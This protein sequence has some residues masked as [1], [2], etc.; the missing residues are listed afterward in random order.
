MEL[1]NTEITS[2]LQYYEESLIFGANTAT[3]YHLARF[4]DEEMSYYEFDYKINKIG[5][6]EQK[7]YYLLE[8]GQVWSS[9]VDINAINIAEFDLPD[10]ERAD[11]FALA[12]FHDDLTDAVVTT[13]RHL[14]LLEN[15]ISDDF[16]VNEI[17][18]ECRSNPVIADINGDG[19]N[20]IV[21][22]TANKIYAF[23]ENLILLANFPVDIPNQFQGNYFGESLFAMNLDDNSKSQEIVA[24]IENTGIITFDHKGDILSH[25][26]TITPMAR[27]SGLYNLEDETYFLSIGNGQMGSVMVSENSLTEQS[28]GKQGIDN[29]SYYYSY[30]PVADVPEN[31]ALLNKKKTFCWPNPVEENESYIRYFVTEDCDVTVNIFNMAGQH[32]KKFNQSD[33][34]TNRFN[35]ITW[36]V[37]DVQSGVYF[38]IVKA[39][40]GGT[41]ETKTVKIMVIK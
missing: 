25:M 22:A 32:I 19:N 28:W 26:A 27:F 15:I 9:T 4:Q 29:N 24:F 38:A 14:F 8:D 34:Q 1:V 40:T 3:G 18:L 20:D 41:T 7:F 39:E 13:D 6:G 30:D 17:P 37:T 33:P 23:D 5:F 35:E 36:N 21:V 12:K 2:N 11:N 16:E 31:E 10:S